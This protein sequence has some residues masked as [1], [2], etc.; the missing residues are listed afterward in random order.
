MHNVSIQEVLGIP[1][2]RGVNFLT[3]RAMFGLFTDDT[4]SWGFRRTES[5]LSFTCG[6]AVAVNA[7]IGTPGK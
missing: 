4:S 3:D 6:V 7:M 2:G 5:I 1:F